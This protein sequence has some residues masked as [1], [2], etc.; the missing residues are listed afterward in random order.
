MQMGFRGLN[1][2]KWIMPC[3]LIDRQSK[4]VLQDTVCFSVKFCDGTWGGGNLKEFPHLR[5]FR[6]IFVLW[7]QNIF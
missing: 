2:S 3:V 6:D 7:Q 4:S 1:N 5:H